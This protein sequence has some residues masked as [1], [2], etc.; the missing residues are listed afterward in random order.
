MIVEGF[1]HKKRL[2]QSVGKFARV[3]WIVSSVDA[4]VVAIDARVVVQLALDSTY[5]QRLIVIVGCQNGLRT[6]SQWTTKNSWVAL[7]AW[8]ALARQAVSAFN[9]IR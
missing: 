9:E 8:T 5:A 3:Q 1:A 2:A 4:G 7:I 6:S